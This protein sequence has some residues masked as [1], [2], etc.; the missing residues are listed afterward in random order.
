VDPTIWSSDPQNENHRWCLMGTRACLGGM[1]NIA[2]MAGG[3]GLEPDQTVRAVDWKVRHRR[4]TTVRAETAWPVGMASPCKRELWFGL[5]WGPTTQLGSLTWTQGQLG[6]RIRGGANRPR[7]I[8]EPGACRYR[9]LHSAP[10]WTVVTGFPTLTPR[11]PDD[12][13]ISSK[14][15][16]MGSLA[17]WIGPRTTRSGRSACLFRLH[18]YRKSGKDGSTTTARKNLSALSWR[19]IRT[20]LWGGPVHEKSGALS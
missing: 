7:G 2:P 4:S 11:F 1:F 8:C 9:I 20:T 18:Q 5:Y 12:V 17:G 3:A 6:P 15:G 13:K 16:P 19:L 14:T 10:L